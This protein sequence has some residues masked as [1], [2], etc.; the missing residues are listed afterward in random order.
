M[1]SFRFFNAF[2]MIFCIVTLKTN[3]L[4]NEGNNIPVWYFGETIDLTHI[5]GRIEGNRCR[6]RGGLVICT[7]TEWGPA[8]VPDEYDEQK[9]KEPDLYRT[10]SNWNCGESAMTLLSSE[11]FK[12]F[13]WKVAHFYFTFCRNFCLSFH[14]NCATFQKT[15]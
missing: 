7:V 11:L 8:V 3:V 6:H 10:L 2:F 12:V 5:E 13:C 1:Y 4:N 14:D 15:D 9:L